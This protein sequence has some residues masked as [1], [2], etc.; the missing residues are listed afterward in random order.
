MAKRKQPKYPEKALAKI[1]AKPE[2]EF[3]PH[4]R[5]MLAVNGHELHGVRVDGKWVVTCHSWPDIQRDHSGKESM[6]EATEAFM[7][8]ALA[9]VVSIR[10]L[11]RS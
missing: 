7:A 8:R 5:F 11:L 4:D 9:G 10:A 3:Q 2:L 6:A 1:A